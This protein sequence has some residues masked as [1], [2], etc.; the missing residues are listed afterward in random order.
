MKEKEGARGEA[1]SRGGGVLGA[2][3]KKREDR[4]AAPLRWAA[5]AP[6]AQS[7]DGGEK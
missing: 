5:A 3:V 7:L 4:F 1:E 2:G 6:P